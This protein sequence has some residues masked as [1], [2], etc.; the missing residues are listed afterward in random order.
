MQ[1]LNIFIIDA[2]DHT[3]TVVCYDY[4][5]TIDA[6]TATSSDT[7]DSYTTSFE[8]DS[9]AAK[10]YINECLKCYEFLPNT[11]AVDSNLTKNIY[12]SHIL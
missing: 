6:T 5:R 10:M 3:E 9:S 12:F 1:N 8:F 4:V 2:K 11:D 7:K